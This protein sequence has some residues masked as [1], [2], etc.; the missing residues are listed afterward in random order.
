MLKI[1]YG[2]EN[3]DKEK[4]IFSN[5]HGKTLVMVPDQYTLEA[6]RQAF[7]HLGI[8]A[9][10]DVE[11]VST[12]SLGENILNELG[13]KKRNFIDKY[14]RH[15]IL[16]KAALRQKDELEV[17]KGMET[18]GSFLD[19]VNNFISEMKQYNSGADDLRSLAESM[20]D[21]SYTQKKLL[22]VYKIFADYE[23]QIEGKYTDSEDYIDLY[24]SKIPESEEIKNSQIWIYGYDSFAPKALAMV[25][26]L[27]A[28][29][30][31][32][33][34]V[35]TWDEGK[36]DSEIFELTSIVMH[37]VE[38]LADSLGVGHIRYEIPSCFELKDKNPSLV[39]IEKELYTMPSAKCMDDSGITLVEAAGL[40]N[41]V[42][43]AASYVLQLVRDR[44]LRYKDI[45][46]VCNDME[47]RGAI[48]E[49]VFEEY[50]IEVFSDTKRDILANP[51]VQYVTSLIDVVIEKYSTQSLMSMLKSGFG[52][53]TVDEISELENYAIKYKIKGTMWKKPFK[54]GKAEYKDDLQKIDELRQKAIAGLEELEDVFKADTTAEFIKGLY[55]YI[56]GDLNLQQKTLDFIVRQEEQE[57]FDLAD[58]TA[59]V[60]ESITGILN[61]IYEIMGE[62]DFDPEEFRDMF[63]VG[64]GQ[65]EVGLLPPTEDGLIL[66]NIQRSRSGRVKA[67]VVI[68]A[69]EGILQQEKPTQGLFSAEERE[70]FRQ[71]GKELCKVDSIRFMEEK[72]AIYRTLSAADEYLWVSYSLS[73]TEGAQLKPSSI[74]LK[75]KELFPA[76]MI[77]QD[78][79]NRD[80][81]LELAGG[82]VNGLR[83]LTRALQD[84]GEGKPLSPKWAEVLSW[85]EE[86]QKET[87]EPVKHGL[88]FRNIQ[89]DLGQKAAEALYKRNVNQALSLSPSKLERFSRCPFSYLIS[90]GLKPE[91]RRIYEAAPREIGDIYHQCLMKIT[92]ELTVEGLAIT[93]PNSP[94]MTV[95]KERCYEIIDQ[96]VAKI[97]AEYREGLFEAS[98][99]ESYRGDRVRETARQVCW[100]AIEQVRAGR[101][102]DIKPEIAF[103][104]K[105]GSHIPP[106]EIELEDQKVYIEGVIDRVD[107]L[108]DDRVK[109]IDYKTGDESFSIKEAQDGYR[110][111]LM[112]YLQAACENEKKPA[113]VF[114]FRITEPMAELTPDKMDQETVEKEIRKNFKLDGILVD[115]PV[116]ITDIAGEF[117]GYSD[118]IPI[119]KTKDGYD[120]S[121]R[122]GQNG[123]M[124]EEDF[125][126]LQKVV[127][128]KIK[129]AC[130]DLLNGRIDAHPMK[131]RDKSAC[132]YCQYK[133]ICR[134]DTVFEGCRYN[135]VG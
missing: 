1:Y 134:F 50:G 117:G 17:F 33:N 29:A 111:Q 62:E 18:R 75:L 118:I 115:D 35:L 27:M 91:E 100:T 40:Y 39:H 45:R 65:V 129:D 26:Q 70:I 19:S 90:Y 43:S 83:H 61:Q 116:V 4:F 6:E 76:A 41:E 44:G 32:V 102:L 46:L 104:R 69:N 74:F 122:S 103:G 23:R 105:E 34:L 37:N 8:S 54:R 14:G 64:L 68:G 108:N 30:N 2:R 95:T 94:W 128:D 7:R 13:G 73:D 131:T 21:G 130:Q 89:E 24:L 127:Y 80:V 110:L 120:S 25:G 82:K 63:L 42:E 57:L 101:I 79:I 125:R 133:G 9:L 52:D 119:K 51:I 99:V 124:T 88:A 86:N 77:Q 123:L 72:L 109:I 56:A 53:L 112:V 31:D 121:S 12:S 106:I 20:P 81:E 49:R 58:E 67:L 15:M 10:M 3:L 98:N 71:D 66:G 114:Y 5:I 60:W 11:I 48:I 113:G 107:Y 87:L 97:S 36:S 59:R 85:F 78:V 135:I 55:A 38:A 16:Y 47:E 22:D 92:Q 132:T 28:T 84:V 96:E 93:D 126:N